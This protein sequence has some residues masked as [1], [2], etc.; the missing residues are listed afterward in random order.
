MTMP[1]LDFI[2]ENG[3]FSVEI[4][5]QKNAWLIVGIL[6]YFGIKLPHK[7]YR[8]YEL[9]N[10]E[11]LSNPSPEPG[12]IVLVVV[13]AVLLMLLLAFSIIWLAWTLWGKEVVSIE[14]EQL[15]VRYRIGPAK[16]ERS[17]R[18]NQMEKLRLALERN[19]I[20][21]IMKGGNIAFDFQGKT[22]RFGWTL[23]EEDAEDLVDAL[24]PRLPEK[25]I[26][27]IR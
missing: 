23:I 1:R 5:T 11:I 13:F 12:M 25:V 7:G 20:V 19:P 16:I 8:F 15:V 6:L 26:T 18:L 10:K 21:S 17:Y 3:Q 4:H 9:L 2:D 14:R 22:H 27:L 24:R